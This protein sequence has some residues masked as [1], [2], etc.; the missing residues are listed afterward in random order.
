M[1]TLRSSDS[2]D[3]SDGMLV[4]LKTR[5]PSSVSR[6][7]DVLTLLRA[8]GEALSI[9]I[10]LYISVRCHNFSFKPVTKRLLRMTDMS[11]SVRC[12]QG[13]KS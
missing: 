8:I 13:V 7:S 11:D 1:T 5:L 12:S 4:M 10:N 3:T 6:S 2:S 9:K